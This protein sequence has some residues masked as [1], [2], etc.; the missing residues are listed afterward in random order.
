MDGAPGVT[1]GCGL[2][3]ARPL[4]HSSQLGLPRALVAA[5]CLALL[6]SEANEGSVC[7]MGNDA[8]ILT[9]TG[10]LIIIILTR[11]GLITVET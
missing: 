5:A 4:Q 11:I 1:L 7:A 3:P 2:H 10:I 6:F 9:V 8:G